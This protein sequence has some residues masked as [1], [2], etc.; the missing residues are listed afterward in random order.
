M[1]YR[2]QFAFHVAPPGFRDEQFHYSF[3]KENAPI[4]VFR[5]GTFSLSKL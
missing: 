3:D 2:P 5:I 4:A 1:I